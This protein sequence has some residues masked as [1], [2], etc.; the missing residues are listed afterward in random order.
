M[1][2]GVSKG[3][4]V[5]A[6]VLRGFLSGRDLSWYPSVRQIDGRGRPTFVPEVSVYRGEYPNPVCR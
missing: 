5:N 2:R 1:V 4:S 6:V 3:F